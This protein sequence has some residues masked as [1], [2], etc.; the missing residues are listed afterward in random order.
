MFLQKGSNIGI[1]EESTQSQKTVSISNMIIACL[2]VI[3]EH[4]DTHTHMHMHPHLK[5]G[6]TGRANPVPS[7]KN[8]G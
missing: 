1:E 2:K 6:I 7:M 5:L 3:L 8:E 4:E